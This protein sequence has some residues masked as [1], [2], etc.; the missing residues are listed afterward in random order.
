ML[1][2]AGYCNT[3]EPRDKQY[4]LVSMTDFNG[5]K[6]IPIA[7]KQ[8]YGKEVQEVYRDVVSYFTKSTVDLAVLFDKSAPRYLWL[9][10][11]KHRFNR[12][13]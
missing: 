4:G 8:D 6:D 3:G 2:A 5:S 12:E 1:E 10:D 9:V 7:L 11:L 13:A